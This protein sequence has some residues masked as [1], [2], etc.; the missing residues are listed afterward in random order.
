MT[1]GVLHADLQRYLGAM[2]ALRSFAARFD[3][4]SVGPHRLPQVNLDQLSAEELVEYRVLIGNML[5]VANGFQ[6]RMRIFELS[7]LAILDGAQTEDELRVKIAKMQ[8]EL[9]SEPAASGGNA[10]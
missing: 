8:G 9:T 6:T 7:S 1:A 4:S 10:P 2:V 5:G 3:T